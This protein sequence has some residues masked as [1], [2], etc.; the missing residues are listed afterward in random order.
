MSEPFPDAAFQALVPTPAVTF[1]IG[2][3]G[4]VVLLRP[5][6]LSERWRWLLRFMS[7]PVFRVR[8]DATGSEVWRACDGIHT[9]AE[10]MARVAA[11]RPSE[12]DSPQRT[13][14]FL[15]EL[16]LGGFLRLS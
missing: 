3:E 16:A 13:A 7:K 15:R 11:M 14:L 5:K 12:T 4:R 9:V 8:L 2:E 1:E 10:I 6:V